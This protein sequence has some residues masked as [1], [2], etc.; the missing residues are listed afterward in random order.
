V[1]DALAREES[2]RVMIKKFKDGTPSLQTW[3][4]SWSEKKRPGIAW[5]NVYGYFN[6]A[7]GYGGYGVILRND[8]A[9]PIIAATCFTRQRFTRQRR[10]SQFFQVL[11][12]LKI[13]LDLAVKNGCL[14]L[15][16][17]C[18]VQ[19]AIDLLGRSS[20]FNIVG[21]CYLD[22]ACG[23]HVKKDGICKDCTKTF[24]MVKDATFDTLVPVISELKVVQAKVEESYFRLTKISRH[25]NEAAHFLAKMAKRD[26]LRG[27]KTSFKVPSKVSKEMKPA[28]FP[29]ELQKILWK[30]AFG[31]DT[32][33]SHSLRLIT[34]KQ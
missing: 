21:D 4:D 17:G 7:K 9:R 15:A 22:D 2:F 34:A 24:V 14:R 25:E 1:K 29:R 16:V 6:K 27:V 20:S 26:A 30:D 3:I 8:L 23:S 10:G 12:G 28:D 11:S 31:C 5:L 13:G 32:R 33:Y 18:N 19:R